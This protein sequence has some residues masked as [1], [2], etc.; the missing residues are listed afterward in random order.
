MHSIGV[1]HGDVKP[2]NVLLARPAE[3]D[4]APECWVCDFGLAKTVSAVRSSVRRSAMMPG[5]AAEGGTVG[6]MA[7]ETSLRNEVV[8]GSDVFSLGLV[9][10]SGLTGEEAYE[11]VRDAAAYASLVGREGLRPDVSMLPP[12]CPAGLSGMLGRCWCADPC[13]RLT[14]AELVEELRQLSLEGVADG[15][16]AA[17]AQ[18]KGAG[19]PG[20]LAASDGL[21]AVEGLERAV[22]MQ[23]VP[24]LVGL[25]SSARGEEAERAAG[26]LR[27]I[28][29][30]SEGGTQAVADGGAIVPL[31]G[32]LSS[33]RG[34]EAERAAEALWS[35]AAGSEAHR[36]AVVDG[37]AIVPLVG[38]L[39]S[40]RGEEAER[41]A[42]ALRTIAAGSETRRQTVVVAGGAAAF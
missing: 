17:V 35:I 42:G 15:E 23:D 31:V 7:P 11:G 36:Q 20:P 33:A 40:A 22:Q 4:D 28:A 10:W 3:G 18:A 16:A 39:S 6:Y 38:L 27:N 34:E 26:A 2:R 21:P 41:A 9:L 12:G 1:V 29:A 8:P 25:L 24:R 30:G 37:N 19:V 13:D 32:L 5:L 14:S